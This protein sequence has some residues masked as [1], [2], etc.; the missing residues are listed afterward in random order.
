[1]RRSSYQRHLVK[2]SYQHAYEIGRKNLDTFLLIDNWCAH[3]RVRKMGGVGMIEQATGYPIGHHALECD[4]APT[5]GMGCWD[6]VDSALD[7][8]DRHCV[9]CV[10]RKAKGFPNISSL[11]ADRDAATRV[12]AER[13]ARE[14]QQIERCRETRV[15]T[16]TQLRAT[17]SPLGQTLVDHLAALDRDGPDEKARAEFVEA[18]RLA[19]DVASP[20][21]VDHL[22]DLVA[23]REVWAMD[24]VIEALPALSTDGARLAR[25]A[26]QVLACWGS[27]PAADLL[28]SHAADAPPTLADE[29]VRGLIHLARPYRGPF[30]AERT[31]H[32]GPLLALHAARPTEVEAAISREFDDHE[33][34]GLD[35][36]AR[37]VVALG[38]AKADLAFKFAR[39]VVSKLARADHLDEM[40]VDNGEVVHELRR[41]AGLAYAHAPTSMDKL[42]QSYLPGA[43]EEGQARVF[44]VYRHVLDFRFDCDAP[45]D[46]PASRSALHRLIWAAT[47][48]HPDEV[49]QELQSVFRGGPSRSK[50]CAAE[51]VE[52]LLGAALLIADRLARIDETPTPTDSLEAMTQ[53]TRRMS[54]NGLLLGFVSWA[55]SGSRGSPE[56]I[57]RYLELLDQVPQTRPEMRGALV[58]E[59]SRLVDGPDALRKVLPRLYRSMLGSSVHERQAA[60]TAFKE[61]DRLSR[62]DAPALLYEA[63]IVLLGDPYIAPVRAAVSALLRVRTPDVLQDEVRGRLAA[64]IQTYGGSTRPELMVDSVEAFLRLGLR[65]GEAESEVG[66]WLIARLRLCDPMWIR[67]R[68]LGFA[69]RLGT[70]RTF[71]SLLAQLLEDGPREAE[72]VIDAL[73]RLKPEQVSAHAG[74]IETAVEAW[75]A[76]SHDWRRTFDFV[77]IFT[78]VR[79]WPSADRLLDT[80]LAKLPDTTRESTRRAYVAHLKDAVATERALAERDRRSFEVSSARWLAASQS[81]EVSETVGPIAAFAARLELA[82]SLL[83]LNLGSQ[84]QSQ[85]LRD[86]A[87]A[88]DAAATDLE[89]L[90]IATLYSGLAEL[91]RSAASIIEWRAAV[92][93]GEADADRH[94]RAAQARIR[95]WRTEDTS[96]ELTVMADGLLAID[97]VTQV[98]SSLEDLAWL[99][100]AVPVRRS[101]YGGIKLPFAGKAEEPSA[102]PPPELAVAFLAFTVNGAPAADTHFLAPGQV[103]DLDLEVR[104]SRWPEGAETL[105]LTPMSLEPASAYDFP[106]FRLERPAGDAPYRLTARGRVLLKVGQNLNARPFEFRYAARFLPLDHEQPVSVVGQRTLRIESVD[107]KSGGLT[108]YPALDGKIVEIR[109][110]LRSRPGVSPEALEAL[111]TV[112]TPLVNFAGR[113]VQDNLIREP[114]SEARVQTEL[115]DQLRRH[116]G[117]GV[118][119]EEHP[120]SAGGISDLSFRGL[121]VELKAERNRNLRLDDC[122]AFLAQTTSY[123]VASGMTV[124]IL[125][126]VDSSPKLS[127]PFPVERGLEILESDGKGDDVAIVTLLIQGNLARPSDLSN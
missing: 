127:A 103:H 59:F 24:A 119:L 16:R 124:G 66:D 113:A 80:A 53:S 35:T 3:V 91:C 69:A 108:G 20:A 67:Q 77:E 6:L 28:A 81:S 82:R 75:P 29:A 87:D 37:G 2:D 86:G 40:D 116:P 8:H 38:E 93:T 118:E 63:L 39:Q 34:G 64:L 104:V 50:L 25:A 9:G 110:V 95:L 13:Q 99:S 120:A 11:V 42:L 74:Q 71:S 126:V 55:A 56:R 107:L 32:P 79:A 125:C 58:S 44:S 15:L 90:G 105:F 96:P 70:N 5:G 68:L 10:H 22:F 98:A 76:Q 46:T 89:N 123:V 12:E 49:M 18:V 26:L 84:S 54:L 31:P 33:A 102:P 111:I 92:V 47:E 117:L 36:A 109:D 19:P 106:E 62:E 17:L 72:A 52:A 43:S 1:M 30:A 4:H 48:D 122:K 114:W 94:L 21:L 27:R 61:M 65:D 41:A 51:H 112:L 45:A 88:L 60:A 14:E 85:R 101:R 100:I 97:D 7:F 115:R 23:E 121:K 83:G 57:D 73:A 78:Q